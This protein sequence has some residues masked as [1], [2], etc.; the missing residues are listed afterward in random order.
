M[1]QVFFDGPAP[2][3]RN[4]FENDDFSLHPRKEPTWGRILFDDQANF[5]QRDSIAV[6]VLGFGVGAFLANTNIDDNFQRHARS[7]VVHASSDEWYNAIHANKELGDGRYTLPVFALAAS[8]RYLVDEDSNFYAI[9]QWGDR[10]I[11]GCLV[12]AAPTLV[13]QQ[14][15]GGSR[16][17]EHGEHSSYWRPLRDNNGVSGHSF[18]G[19][20]PFITAAKMSD[21]KALKTIF[22]GGSLLAPL[23]RVN[24]GAHFASQAYLGWLVAFVA[25]SAVDVTESP[26]N[27]WHLLPIVDASSSGLA[28]E[29]RW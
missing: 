3:L 29:R 27:R 24:D 12:G 16:P 2:M 4:A 9:S 7:S 28:L 5:Y 18:M 13:L 26:D 14:M 23:S 15:I 25:A 1:N 22:Y 20:M 8:T 21:N 11:R 17:N 10:S 6:L 19:A